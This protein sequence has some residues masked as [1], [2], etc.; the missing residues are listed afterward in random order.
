MNELIKQAGSILLIFLLFYGYMLPASATEQGLRYRGDYTYGHEVNIFCPEINSQCYW[1]SPD[2]QKQVREQLIN[3]SVSNSVKPYES[4]CIIVIGKKTK[5]LSMGGD[6]GFAENYAG[7]F[8]VNSIL[9]LCDKSNIVTQG[10]L[11]HHR[12]VLDSVNNNQMAIS[13]YDNL[14]LDIQ[15]GQDMWVSVNTACHQL[16]GYAILSG[17]KI[18]LDIERSKKIA[19]TA[20]QEKL[21]LKLN[22][23]FSSD[24]II[25][26]DGERNLML[27][28]N[29]TELKYQLKDWVY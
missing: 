18:T 9:G 10:D 17:K 21:D 6:I 8:T 1:I 16:T 12:W 7:F 19:C 24:A 25:S 28:N 15:F 27:K 3:I 29:K 4:V 13:E 2:T 5:S 20:K 22:E 14:S 23:L 26:I 11:Q